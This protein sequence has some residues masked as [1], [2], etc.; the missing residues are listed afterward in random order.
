MADAT[1]LSVV[2]DLRKA[3]EQPA[4]SIEVET[5][6]FNQLDGQVCGGGACRVEPIG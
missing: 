1:S 4:F 2:G 6:E 3:P 5:L